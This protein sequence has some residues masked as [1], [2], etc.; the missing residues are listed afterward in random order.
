MSY[1]NNDS[2]FILRTGTT[3]ELGYR[4]GLVRG[5]LFKSYFLDF[6]NR[7]EMVYDTNSDVQSSLCVTYQGAEDKRGN[8]TRIPEPL[9]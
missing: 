1:P 6:D 4:A 3:I 8:P 5:Q 9:S 7:R 2:R